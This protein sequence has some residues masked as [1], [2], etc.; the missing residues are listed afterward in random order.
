MQ[1]IGHPNPNMNF[2]DDLTLRLQLPLV[3]QI[4]RDET[5]LEAERRGH[6]V[7]PD[8]PV[9]RANVCATI[10]RTGAA[11]RANILQQIATEVTSR[12]PVRRLTVHQAA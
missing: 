3:A 6:T 1:I 5:W 12:M 9:V 11:M 2:P 4:I 8:D 10:L 7:P